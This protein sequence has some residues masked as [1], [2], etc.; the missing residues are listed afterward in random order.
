MV[1]QQLHPAALISFSPLISSK[2]EEGEESSVQSL[3]SYYP[4]HRAH[5]AHILVNIPFPSLWITHTI[6]RQSLVAIPP[7]ARFYLFIATDVLTYKAV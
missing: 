3:P 4:Q 2:K 5:T 1:I 7:E 6:Y